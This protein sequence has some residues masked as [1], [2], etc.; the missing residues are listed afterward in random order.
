MLSLRAVITKITRG[1]SS[2]RSEKKK[3]RLMFIPGSGNKFARRKKKKKKGGGGGGGGEK[4]YRVSPLGK[5]RYLREEV[6]VSVLKLRLE[7][8]NEGT[9]RM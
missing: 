9:V 3:K 2:T 7:G 1:A 6:T 8:S 4:S 5:H